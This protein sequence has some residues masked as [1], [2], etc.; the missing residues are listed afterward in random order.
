MKKTKT[1]VIVSS[2]DFDGYSVD[3]IIVQMTALKNMYSQYTNLYFSDDYHYEYKY[4][5]LKGDRL[6]TDAEYEYRLDGEHKSKLR[7]EENE[8]KQYEKLKTKFESKK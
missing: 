1:D 6:E 3:E 7:V 4:T 8:R 5:T 2:Y